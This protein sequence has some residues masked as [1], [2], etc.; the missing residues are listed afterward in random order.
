M[1]KVSPQ[2][3]KANAYRNN[4]FPVL[5][6]SRRKFCLFVCDIW[7]SLRNPYVSGDFESFVSSDINLPH[8][9]KILSQQSSAESD[10]AGGDRRGPYHALG[11][12]IHSLRGSVHAL[13]GFKVIFLTLLCFSFAAL[14]GLG[15]FLIFDNANT[16]PSP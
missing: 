8:R 11:S 14:S 4:V 12:F 16:D 15:G 2:I 10:E 9:N 3:I 1:A 5:P 7:A 13:L 6:G